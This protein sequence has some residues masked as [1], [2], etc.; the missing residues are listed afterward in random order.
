VAGS[1]GGDGA[2]RCSAGGDAALADVGWDGGF[3]RG[4]AG[5]R[6]GAVG[7]AVHAR[8][9]YAFSGYSA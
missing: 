5:A 2:L 4:A 3:H 9:H 7:A 8:G 1:G 6:A